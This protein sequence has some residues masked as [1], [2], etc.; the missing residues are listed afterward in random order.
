[1]G[2][3]VTAKKINNKKICFMSPYFHIMGGGERYLLSIASYLSS[4]NKVT[5]FSDRDQ[6]EKAEKYFSISLNNVDFHPDI[7]KKSKS[8]IFRFLRNYDFLVYM[9][10][11]GLPL[12]FAKRN[13]LMIQSPAHTPENTL[14]NRIKLK[15][16]KVIC[17]S[18][19]MKAYLKNNLGIE[20]RTL[21]PGIDTEQ[22][23]NLPDDKE[24]L[25]LTVGRFFSS[26]MHN[27]N[28]ELLVDAF[29]NNQDN[30]FRNWKLILAGSAT[31][32]SA[33]ETLERIK[34]KIRSKRI[35]L[36][37]N[38]SFNDLK[39]LYKRAR[40]Y[41]HAAGFGADP[42]SEPQK[43]EHFGITTV[44]AMAAGCVPVVFR[45]GGQIDI[46]E[47]NKS[48]LFWTDESELVD[49]TAKLINNEKMMNRMADKARERA[50]NFSLKRLYERIDEN[51]I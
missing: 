14:I 28:H 19:F 24:N 4:D 36:Q 2:K 17:Y 7:L 47:G 27:K 3:T 49:Q 15:G 29:Q 12:P 1:M 48:G 50:D 31:E 25:I 5:I 20:A 10:D 16:W 33:L 39:N 35:S 45:G 30:I 26:F 40:I 34:K 43:F 46:V 44:E 18:D 41:W 8:T 51:F 13:F 22:F 38:L 21:P 23:K 9:T 6:I 37:V 11:G 32:K 42:V